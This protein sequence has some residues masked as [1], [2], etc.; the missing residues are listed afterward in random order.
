MPGVRFSEEVFDEA[1]SDV[2]THAVEFG[3]DGGVV[4]WVRGG[5]EGEVAAELGDYGAVG[6]GYY[7]SRDFVGAGSERV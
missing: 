4:G 3:I 2:V 6:E 7:F 5:G 1:Q